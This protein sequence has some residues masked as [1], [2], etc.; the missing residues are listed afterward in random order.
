M[1]INDLIIT[2]EELRNYDHFHKMLDHALCN[3]IF[4]TEYLS[5]FKSYQLI[6]LSQFEDDKIYVH[7]G[8]HRCAAIWLSGRDTLHDDEYEIEFYNYKNYMR[9]KKSTGWFTPFDPRKEVRLADF[10]SFK[11]KAEKSENLKEYVDKNRHMYC[12]PRTYTKI[13][14]MRNLSNWH[15]NYFKEL[16]GVS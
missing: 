9:P 4:D 8:H 16:S 2:Q 7:D 3:G 15:Q 12:K 5:Q 10:I 11:L 1:K 13:S 14:E 6:K